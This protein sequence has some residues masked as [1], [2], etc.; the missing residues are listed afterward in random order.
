M[1]YRT[2]DNNGGNTNFGARLLTA[3]NAAA[4]FRSICAGQRHVQ[5]SASDVDRKHL[6][7]GICFF[8]LRQRRIPVVDVQ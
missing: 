1:A 3:V 2:M 6:A 5:C 8:L 7:R 4:V